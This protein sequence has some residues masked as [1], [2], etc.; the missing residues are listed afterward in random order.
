MLTLDRATYRPGDLARVTITSPVPGVTAL[1]TLERGGVI[2]ARVVRLD[3]TTT[4]VE[5]PVGDS[6]TAGL[7][8][9]ATLIQ[10]IKSKPFVD[11]RHHLAVRIRRVGNAV[12]Q[13]HDGPVGRT[14]FDITH[15]QPRF[16]LHFQA[17]FRNANTHS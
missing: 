7:Q 15:C 6:A 3:G 2:D 4:A 10:G 11:K 16:E 17:L 8:L 12:K 9:V 5:V 14:G 1:L 13:D